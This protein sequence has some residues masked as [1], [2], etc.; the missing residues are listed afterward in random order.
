MK[1]NLRF[2]QQLKSENCFIVIFINI[3]LSI[4]LSHFYRKKESLK[5]VKLA[6]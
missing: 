2:K 4:K 3:Y 1:P 5:G 6:N